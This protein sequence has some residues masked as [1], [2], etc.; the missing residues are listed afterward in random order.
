MNW[1]LLKEIPKSVVDRVKA[2]SAPT[3]DWR[4]SLT[5]SDIE[6]FRAS[7][8][9][10]PTAAVLSKLGQYQPYYSLLTSELGQALLGPDIEQCNM[11]LCKIAENTAT[12]DEKAE[13]R[14]YRR[15]I[16]RHLDRIY[17]YLSAAKKLRGE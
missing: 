14:A 8:G 17:S 3:D 15:I 12:I 10:R 16:D 2:R 7:H 6:D 1:K 4:V 9:A 11:L 13:Y 5:P